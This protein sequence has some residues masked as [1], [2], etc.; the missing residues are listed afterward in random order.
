MTGFGR[1]VQLLPGIRLCK[2]STSTR[3][4]AGTLVASHDRCAVGEQ[5]QL[6]SLSVQSKRSLSIGAILSAIAHMAACSGLLRAFH[7]PSP[8]QNATKSRKAFL[9]VPAFSYY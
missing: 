7:A 5:R 4:A 9:C 1:T 8:F 6:L 3:M 2:E